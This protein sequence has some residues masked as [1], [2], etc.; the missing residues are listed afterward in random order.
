MAVP[1][2]LLKAGQPDSESFDEAEVDSRLE[3]YFGKDGT[4]AISFSEFEKVLYGHSN[5]ARVKAPRIAAE[6]EAARQERYAILAK[7]A[8]RVGS[9]H[10]EKLESKRKEESEA[11]QREAAAK[12]QREGAKRMLVLQRL[13]SGNRRK[14]TRAP[15]K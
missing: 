4:E 1:R 3:K 11:R 5:R 13:V 9:P 7:D 2:P 14:L 12:R 6:K 8:K 10:R 15:Q